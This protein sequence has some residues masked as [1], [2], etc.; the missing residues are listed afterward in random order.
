VNRT[1]D[2]AHNS[3]GRKK[4]RKKERKKGAISQSILGE[5]GGAVDEPTGSHLTTQTHIIR[6]SKHTNN[7]KIYTFK[8][9]TAL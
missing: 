6:N 7:I 4:E 2:L 9:T 8:Y 5:G 1:I 3:T